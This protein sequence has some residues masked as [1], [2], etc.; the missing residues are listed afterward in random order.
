MKTSIR[1]SEIPNEYIISILEG[2]FSEN[3]ALRLFELISL[4]TS[5]L[6]EE[7]PIDTDSNRCTIYIKVECGNL[8]KVFSIS[9]PKDNPLRNTISMLESIIHS[10]LNIYLDRVN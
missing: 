10:S 3:N 7:L 2:N 6:Q 5:I 1:L 4:K 8:N 9:L